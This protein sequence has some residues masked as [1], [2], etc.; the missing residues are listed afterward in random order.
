MRDLILVA[1]VVAA[2]PAIVFRPWIGIVYWVGFGLMN[3]HR[4][5]WSFA[6]SLPFAQI[7][8]VATM[9]GIVVT[10]DPKKVKGGAATGVLLLFVMWMAFTTTL[11]L[12][13]DSATPMLEKTVKI[14]IGT[15][16]ALL[17][18]HRREHIIAVIWV[19]LASIGFYA[20]KGG[21][22]TL[23]TLGKYRVYGPAETYIAENNALALATVMTIP[24]WYYLYA[25]YSHRLLRVGI[26]GCMALSSASVFGSY[27]RGAFLAIFAMSLFLWAKS[28]QKLLLG[29]MFV[30]LG[31][32]LVAFMPSQWEERMNTIREPTEEDSANSR[33]ETWKMLWALALDRP[34]IG[35]GFQPYKQWIFDMYN[36]DFGRSYS[37]H[38]IWFQV[39][40]EHG[41]IGLFLF[42]VFW[43]LVWR[44][45]S[46]VA[47][48]SAGVQDEQWA[49]WL[50]Q[51]TKVSL[52]GYFVGGTFLNLAYWDM[53]Y[54][55]FV[56]IAVT[57]HVLNEN[58]RVSAFTALVAAAEPTPQSSTSP[59]QGKA[60]SRFG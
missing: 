23:A 38:S 4:L 12:V 29:V 27:S 57:A 49:Y 32:G 10:K 20:I 58:R 37:A 30:L 47:Q 28:R 6:Y 7:I 18:L 3:P 8:A 13:P 1:I 40:G 44:T 59:P 2:L 22:F 5:A 52:I 48:M 46:R 17:V 60:D 31:V 51:M 39:L 15:L 43:F 26:L 14:Q 11:A 9:I 56:C 50:A 36:P 19:I 35:G 34:L 16:L 21:I 42:L 53:P 24:F 55:L 45:C 54:Y 33:L 25:H 41:F